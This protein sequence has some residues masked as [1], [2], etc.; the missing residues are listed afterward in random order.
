MVIF[1]LLLLLNS[2]TVKKGGRIFFNLSC[3]E[4]FEKITKGS[5]PLEGFLVHTSVLLLL[6][7]S[8]L[9]LIFTFFRMAFILLLERS[10]SLVF[11]LAVIHL[12]IG[13]CSILTFA[14]IWELR[15]KHFCSW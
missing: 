6:W 10:L 12:G 2:Y 14:H 13:M 3:L 9:Y 11:I 15:V 7:F 5:L 8:I 4:S 1:S